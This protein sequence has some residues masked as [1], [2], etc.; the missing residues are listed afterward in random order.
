MGNS[1][2]CE[3]DRESTVL[4]SGDSSHNYEGSQDNDRTYSVVKDYPQSGLLQDKGP[5]LKPCPHI[6]ADHH[7]FLCVFPNANSSVIRNL[8]AQPAIVLE[9]PLEDFPAK[10]VL[11]ADQCY[12]LVFAKDACLAVCLPAG[13]TGRN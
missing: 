4:E 2:P 9:A 11:D 1:L 10:V 7:L 13:V 3:A 6:T 5:L 8:H 12:R